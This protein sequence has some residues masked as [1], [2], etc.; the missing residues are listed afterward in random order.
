VLPVGQGNTC[1]RRDSD[2]RADAR[3]DLKGD[4]RPGKCLCL[5]PSTT[6][7]KGSPPF[8]RQTILPCRARSSMAAVI[9]SWVIAWC[10]PRFT[11]VNELC[12]SPHLI[13]H[14]RIDVKIVDDHVRPVA[15]SAAP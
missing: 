12:P 11:R 7:T 5:F 1:A 6:K 14:L 9:S 13:E 3:Y 8:N 10:P 15:G 2:H 4:S